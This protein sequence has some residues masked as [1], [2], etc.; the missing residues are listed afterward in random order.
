MSLVRLDGHGAGVER[1]LKLYVFPN[2]PFQHLFHVLD[3]YIQV[4]NPRIH[5]LLPAE[6]EQLSSERGCSMTRLQ[7][8]VDA[9]TQRTILLRALLNNL[10]VTD[11]YTE[12]VIEIV[13][14]TSGKPPHCLHLLRLPDLIPQMP[15]LAHTTIPATPIPAHSTRHTRA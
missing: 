2:E 7:D 3:H 11:D 4:E 9:S 8:F 13:S 1:G 14:H 6:C 15:M 10:S 5:H 12:Q